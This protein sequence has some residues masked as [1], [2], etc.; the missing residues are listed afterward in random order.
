MFISK[1]GEKSQAQ[2]VCLLFKMNSILYTNTCL[3]SGLAYIKQNH[4]N[5]LK[6]VVSCA[7]LTIGQITQEKG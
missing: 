7:F 3:S 6:K 4:S 1:G 2:L 5:E